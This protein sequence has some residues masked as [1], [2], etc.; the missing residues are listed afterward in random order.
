MRLR[1]KKACSLCMSSPRY[2]IRGNCIYLS[3]A[4]AHPMYHHLTMSTLHVLSK[5]PIRR[6]SYSRPC[7]GVSRAGYCHSKCS[8]AV[9]SQRLSQPWARSIRDGRFASRRSGSLGAAELI[10]SGV[11]RCA[12]KAE[13]ALMAGY[14][15]ELGPDVQETLGPF[16]RAC[17]SA[18]TP[19]RRS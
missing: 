3:S 19:D 12:G 6:T 16:A 13:G 10:D 1:A 17:V 14:A 9:Y 2:D 18:T 4:I 5:D 7:A 15:G 11:G 8:G